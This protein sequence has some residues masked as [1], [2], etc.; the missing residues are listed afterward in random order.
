MEITLHHYLILSVLLFIVGAIGAAVR[1]N[2]LVVFIS[3]EIMMGA[4]ILAL[5]AFARWNLLPGGKASALMV[6][7]IT[8]VQAA[9]GLAMAV[10]IFRTHRTVRV[11]EMRMLRG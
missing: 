10:A 4:G 11:D 9:V 5:L 6:L 2:V 1:R 7:L 8:A 3:I